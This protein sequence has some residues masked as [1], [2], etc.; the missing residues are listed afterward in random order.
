M[1]RAKDHNFPPYPFEEVKREPTCRKKQEM[2]EQISHRHSD[3]GEIMK[4][5]FL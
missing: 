2:E 5:S 3:R 4:L 1:A